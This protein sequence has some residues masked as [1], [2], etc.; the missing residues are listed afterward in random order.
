MHLA[1]YIYIF[2][3]FKDDCKALESSIE[4]SDDEEHI[5]KKRKVANEDVLANQI[6]NGALE[7]L[8][9]LKLKSLFSY[10]LSS[11]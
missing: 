8:S 6:N 7:A 5:K 11:F 4:D 2:F 10:S 1:T 9:G 3:F